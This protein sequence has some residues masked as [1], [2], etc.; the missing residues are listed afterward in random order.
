MCDMK[1]MFS[2]PQPAPA[3]PPPVIVT[4]STSPSH[5]QWLRTQVANWRLDGTVTAD[6]ADAI[7]TRYTE[8]RRASLGR[9]LLILGACFVGVGLIWLVAANLDEFSPLTRFV[10]ITVLW[11]ATLVGAEVAHTRGVRPVA[12]GALRLLAAFAIGGVIFQ[13]AQSLQV[14][15][16]DI[17]LLGAWG[18]AAMI[19]AYVLGAFLPLLLGL[20]G[21]IAWATV[22]IGERIE[23][24]ADGV[25]MLG[26]SAVLVVAVAAIHERGRKDFSSV[27]RAIGASLALITLFVAALPTGEDFALTLL[28]WQIALIA[29]VT[30]LAAVAVALQRRTVPGSVMAACETAGAAL[31]VGAALGLAAWPTSGSALEVSGADTLR[32]VFAVLL[33]VVLAL[34]VAVIGTLRDS[35][36]L[37]AIATLALV[38]FTTFQAFAI[39]ATIITGAWLFLILGVLFIATGYGFDRTRR[40]LAESL[41]DD[42][43]GDSDAPASADAPTNGA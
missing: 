15:A 17:N 26:V 32:S 7:L 38:I 21:V 30:A 27:W 34:G 16:Y 35:R 10:G 3:D 31:V 6:Q 25:L 22:E 12:V 2:P 5:L 24:F 23:T 1:A 8:S 36:L 14:P 9:I 37:P 18:V 20:A 42:T 11:L 28:G 13:A 29:T 19:Q 4:V 33:Y 39:F 40:R 41:D 43:N